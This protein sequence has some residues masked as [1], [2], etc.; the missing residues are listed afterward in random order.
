MMIRAAENS[1]P[2]STLRNGEFLD[3][4][5]G[6]DWVHGSGTGC[7]KRREHH[8]QNAHCIDER[9]GRADVEEEGA[10]MGS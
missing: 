8:H 2:Y 3:R 4:T 6:V 9:V 10:D 5:Q 1:A 7:G